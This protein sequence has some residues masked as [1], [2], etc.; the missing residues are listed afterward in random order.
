[1]RTNKKMVGIHCIVGIFYIV[2]LAALTIVWNS[3]SMVLLTASHVF[4]VV[5]LIL[6][7]KGVFKS[8]KTLERVVQIVFPHDDKDT[9]W[10]TI[11]SWHMHNPNH[12]WVNL[13]HILTLLWNLIFFMNVTYNTMPT[14]TIRFPHQMARDHSKF[15]MNGFAD[16]D[17]S[18]LRLVQLASKGYYQLEEYKGNYG[19][20][21]GVRCGSTPQWRCFAVG[22]RSTDDWYQPLPSDQYDVDLQT[23]VVLADSGG[24]TTGNTAICGAIFI[25]HITGQSNVIGPYYPI[26]D[27]DWA[28]SPTFTMTPP[29][30]NLGV[31]SQQRQSYAQYATSMQQHCSSSSRVMHDNDGVRYSALYIPILP[32]STSVDQVPFILISVLICTCVCP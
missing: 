31:I 26:I 4:F 22:V 10:T 27:L 11:F 21:V 12:N 30:G 13:L 32:R 5:M 29:S 16:M 25:Q 24:N 18:K 7:K 15:G 2:M 1:M 23:S 8:N 3:P 20:N 19:M 17:D 28:A 14:S 9:R 6:R